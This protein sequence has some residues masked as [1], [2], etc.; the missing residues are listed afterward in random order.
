MSEPSAVY[1]PSEFRRVYVHTQGELEGVAAELAAAEALGVDLEMGQLVDRRP[2]GVQRWHHIPALVQIASRSLSV[3]IDAVR[4]KDLSP[5]QP[6]MSG[7]GRKVFLG[8]GQDVALLRDENLAPRNIVDV[9]EIA[10]G[11][12]GRRQDG[13]AALSQ[14]IFGITLDKTLRRTDWLARPLHPGLIRYAHQDAELTLLIYEWL[15]EHYPEAV[16]AHERVQFEPPLSRSPQWLQQAVRRS[17]LEPLLIL[18]ENKLDVNRD[19]DTL[20]ADVRAG[21]LAADAPR[22]VNRLLRVV[23]D[24]G[25]DAMV[26]DVLAYADSQ[27][28][29]VRAAVARALGRLDVREP[30]VL[31]TVQ[32]LRKDSL[33]D[34][35]K[36]ADT[37]ARELRRSKT[38]PVEE[39]EEEEP[40]LDD[41]AMSALR[42]LRESLDPDPS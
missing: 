6:V 32:R 4:V 29:I 22:V 1:E 11:L 34:V 8:G 36:A 35:R 13:M 39:K 5:L 3:V 10:L 37:A 18:A 27:S 7:T 17:S 25:L 12:F 16:V 19:R 24:L 2:G 42:R 33:E 41:D 20:V 23:A 26:P 14:R 31:E 9:G 28:G 30:E 21:L 38:P 40:S 15:R